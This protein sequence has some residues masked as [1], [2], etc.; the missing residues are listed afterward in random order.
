MSDELA[1]P[2]NLHRWR[3]L[4]GSDPDVFDLVFKVHT[5][6]KQLI[7]KT[8]QLA[9]KDAVIEVRKLFG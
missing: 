1:R 4:K 7:A 6:Q 8:E 9:E 5:L 2:I 3:Q